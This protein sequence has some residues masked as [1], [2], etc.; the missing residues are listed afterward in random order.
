MTSPAGASFLDFFILEAGEYVEQIDALLLRAT[1]AG[2]DAESLQRAS[3]ALRGSA[4]MAKLQ[5]F[6]ELA[7]AVE[8][9]GRALRAGSLGWDQALKG[10]LTA[11]VDDLKLLVRAAR[12]WSATE[13]QW[14]AKRIAELSRYAQPAAP[15]TAPASGAS[16]AY[17]ASEAAT[18]A[19]A[20]DGAAAAAAVNPGP[21]LE[22]LRRI[23]A[24]RGVAGV[25]EVSALSEVAEAAEAALH[26]VELGK[27]ITHDHLAMLRAAA[28]LLRAIAAGIA[29]GQ[30]VTTATP[31]YR[32]YLS[33]LDAMEA[34]DRGG[35]RVVPIADL[36][37]TDA[38]PHIVE[39]A[40]HPPTT[41]G[42]RFRME[43]VSLGEHLHRVIDEARRAV[44]DIQ[45]EH[46]R[47]ELGRAL[48]AIRATASSFSQMAVAQTVEGHLER[49]G[50]LNAAALDSISQFAASISPPPQLPPPVA[51]HSV[52]FRM[53]H[54]REAVASLG[55]DAS[56]SAPTAPPMAP[57]AAAAPPAAPTQ[58]AAP[59]PSGSHARVFAAVTVPGAGAAAPL[60]P[61]APPPAPAPVRPAAP[62]APVAAPSGRPPA[63]DAASA[64]DSAI[65]AFDTLS[66]ERFAEPVALGD[67][68]VPVDALLYR[69]QAA[70]ARAIEL[71]DAMRR[72]GGAPAPEALEELYDLLDLAR[73]PEPAF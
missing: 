63:S 44:D 28:E 10:A 43:V 71:R 35:E 65:A 23:R 46:A 18:I 38:G 51:Q 2:P 14:A 6:A 50:D 20:L 64:M 1:P 31:S 34:R 67:D 60:P 8:S 9:V 53:T 72:A 7:S 58:P 29:S 17:F 30:Q 16:G 62:V 3:R 42:Q 15:A 19:A 52:P 70:L 55:A 11:A 22:A 48:R 32:A 61:A 47:G 57:P 25:R 5:A 41:P 26:P 27:P 12:S 68:V 40:Q 33:A 49:T 39:K 24:L 56:R 4:T 45:R 66:S 59:R 69:G 36:F 54:A 37:Y 21:S 73:V 13:D